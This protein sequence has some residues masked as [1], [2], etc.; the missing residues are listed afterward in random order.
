MFCLMFTLTA[1]RR[2][3]ATAAAPWR[4]S[5]GPSRTPRPTSMH[6]TVQT[7]TLLAGHRGWRTPTMSHVTMWD[8]RE[9]IPG[10]TASPNAGHNK[11]RTPAMSHVTMWDRR[12][13]FAGTPRHARFAL[14][15]AS[16]QGRCPRTGKA[17]QQSRRRRRTPKGND[18]D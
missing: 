7:V 1:M 2:I 16:A 12:R 8:R 11:R 3:T 9:D 4:G 13:T 15:V 5:S 17:T 6:G 14:A 10:H 18:H